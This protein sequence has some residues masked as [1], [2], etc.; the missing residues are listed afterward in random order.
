MKDTVDLR[1]KCSSA[2]NSPPPFLLP[3]HLSLSHQKHSPPV[4]Y[5]LMVKSKEPRLCEPLFFTERE[6]RNLRQ[7]HPC[8]ALS[9]RI[10]VVA[11]AL[12]S[13]FKWTQFL[14]E[15]EL[16]VKQLSRRMRERGRECV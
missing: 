9:V 10:A 8:A 13:I 14:F 4:R 11:S 7:G 6:T 5:Y 12:I 3:L 15:S 2:A 1:S 16:K